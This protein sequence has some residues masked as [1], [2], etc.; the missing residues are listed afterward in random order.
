MN[1]QDIIDFN[2]F[3]GEIL[4]FT[5]KQFINWL[6]RQKS[7]RVFIMSRTDCVATKFLNEASK[8]KNVVYL[9]GVVVIYI[10]SSE[11]PVFR[12]VGDQ[13][14]IVGN[15]AQKIK[16]KSVANVY[17]KKQVIQAI[18]ETIKEYKNGEGRWRFRN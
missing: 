16:I 9:Y 15:I 10:S 1:K 11:F 12:F 7:N 14:L 5:W 18:K 3:E 4:G 2:L 17:H 8:N 13:S 6:Y